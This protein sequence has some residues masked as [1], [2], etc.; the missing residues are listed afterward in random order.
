MNVQPITHLPLKM[1][2]LK[3]RS[4]PLSLD[5]IRPSTLMMM[6][7]QDLYPPQLLQVCRL[8]HRG[9]IG[10]QRSQYKKMKDPIF[11]SRRMLRR[12]NSKARPSMTVSTHAASTFSTFRYLLQT[13]QVSSLDVLARSPGSEDMGVIGMWTP[14]HGC[15]M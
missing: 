3:G 8:E 4:E 1:F 12:R 2:P 14:L 5:T 10:L 9:L 7:K 15:M 6:K 11:S 13:M